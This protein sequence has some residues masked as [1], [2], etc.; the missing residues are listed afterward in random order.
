VLNKNEVYTLT[1]LSGG[2]KGDYG[3]PPAS[4]YFPIPYKDTFEGMITAVVVL[5]I[6]ISM[7]SFKIIGYSFTC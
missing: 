2:V 5:T 6:Y 4:A 3:K 1:T 7:C